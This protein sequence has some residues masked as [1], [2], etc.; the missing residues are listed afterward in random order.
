MLLGQLLEDRHSTAVLVSHQQTVVSSSKLALTIRLIARQLAQAI[1]PALPGLASLFQTWNRPVT[2]HLSAAP[3]PSTWWLQAMVPR[4]LPISL[5]SFIP[6]GCPDY[7]R[8]WANLFDAVATLNEHNMSLT[9]LRA[10]TMIYQ[11]N[12]LSEV[13]SSSP[14]QSSASVRSSQSD[15]SPTP[16]TSVMLEGDQ[17]RLDLPAPMITPSGPC[18]PSPEIAAHQVDHSAAPINQYIQARRRHAA[19]VQAAE[20]GLDPVDFHLHRERQLLRDNSATARPPIVHPRRSPRNLSATRSSP[21]QFFSQE[22]ILDN[23]S[24][25]SSSYSSE[26]YLLANNQDKLASRI[27]EIGN[28]EP[29]CRIYDI[30]DLPECLRLP[31]NAQMADSL[32]KP[33]RQA[34]IGLTPD[35]KYVTVVNQTSNPTAKKGKTVT[36]NAKPPSVQHFR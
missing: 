36:P 18:L 15:T 29:T 9:A 24:S 26:N 3:L 30:E 7:H 20:S 2:S 21:A 34:T 19:N 32:S 17:L 10:C 12:Q 16:I 1:K 6:A 31:T 25:P 22:H 35:R 8:S 33:K 14:P 23:E 5:G 4:N 28:P 27:Y 13:H 11:S